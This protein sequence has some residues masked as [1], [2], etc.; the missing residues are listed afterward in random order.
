MEKLTKKGAEKLLAAAKPVKASLADFLRTIEKDNQEE[1]EKEF[2]NFRDKVSEFSALIDGSAGQIDEFFIA[3]GEGLFNAQVELDK[4]SLQYE[5]E[6]P[7]IAL[8]VAYRIPKVN[9][10]I[11][12]SMTKEKSNKFSV[13]VFGTKSTKS[14]TMQNSVSFEVTTAPPP[15]GFNEGISIGA[16]FITNPDQRDLIFSEIKGWAKTSVQKAII[17]RITENKKTLIMINN[18]NHW[19]FVLPVKPFETKKN[20]LEIVTADP[21]NKSLSTAPGPDTP[22]STTN[23]RITEIH[24]FLMSVALQQETLLKKHEQL[25]RLTKPEAPPPVQE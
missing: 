15:P 6:R 17:K 10:E 7:D 13:L 9:A 23:L 18:E 1:V 3:V 20:V 24:K 16:G 2:E 8:P 12:F 14:E 21:K 25:K 11:K 5:R 19:L 22:A 4:K